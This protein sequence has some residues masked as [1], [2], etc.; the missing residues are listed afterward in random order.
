MDLTNE[1][2]NRIAQ[3]IPKAKAGPGKSG[4]LAQNQ[5]AVL[6]EILWVLRSGVPCATTTPQ[7]KNRSVTNKEG[8]ANNGATGPFHWPYQI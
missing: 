2:G 7:S 3:S 6:N 1:Q 8:P 5:W 4:Q